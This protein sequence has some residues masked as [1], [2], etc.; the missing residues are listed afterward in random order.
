MGMH[1][2]ISQHWRIA[3]TLCLHVHIAVLTGPCCT[4]AAKT[5]HEQ[6]RCIPADDAG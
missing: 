1:M 5:G 2:I 4:E 3:H 6:A